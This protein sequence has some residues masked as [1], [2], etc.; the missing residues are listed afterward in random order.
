MTRALLK[1]MGGLNGGVG[2]F[3]GLL[4]LPQRRGLPDTY[5]TG[6]PGPTEA[7]N[8]GHKGADGGIYGLV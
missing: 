5:F 2:V 4:R 3:R 6:K 8:A 1:A 7:E